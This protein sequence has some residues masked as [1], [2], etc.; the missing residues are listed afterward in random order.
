MIWE[1][2]HKMDDDDV[3]QMKEYSKT[4]YRINIKL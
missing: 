2:T 1:I 4:L 3:S